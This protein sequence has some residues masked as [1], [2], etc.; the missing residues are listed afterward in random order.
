MVFTSSSQILVTF[1]IVLFTFLHHFFSKTILICFFFSQEIEQTVPTTTTPVAEPPL[2]DPPTLCGRFCRCLFT[3]IFYTQLI[4]ISSLVIFLTFRGL[5]FTKNPNFLPKKWYAP[6]LSS[7]ALSGVLSLAWNC[8]FLCNKAA[9]CNLT[10]F[11]SPML[12]FS[13]GVVILSNGGMEPNASGLVQ[14]VAY[15][16]CFFGVF[17]LFY[18]FLCATPTRRRY[19][20]RVMSI[21]TDEQLPARTRVIAVL[22]VFLS[23]FFAAFLVAGIGGASATGTRLDTLFISLIFIG[24]AWNVQ[25]LKNVQVTAVSKAVYVYFKRLENMNAC[26]ALRVTLRSQLG[27]VCIGSTI[28]PVYVPVRM[29][30]RACSDYEN[31]TKD[32]GCIVND[33]VLYCNRW[34][35][36]HVGAYNKGFVQASRDTWMGFRRTAGLEE[37]IDSDITSSICFE[38]ALLVGAISA[39]TSG[40]WGLKTHKDY[41]LQ[42]TIYP[43]II[44]YFVGRVSSAWLQGC[45]LGYYV[46]YSENP[47]SQNFDDT[48]LQRIKDRRLEAAIARAA[49]ELPA[50]LREE[51]EISY[52]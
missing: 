18:G 34:G 33:M 13:V 19:T 28:L 11:L 17:Q 3:T 43:F 41:F 5:V 45:V 50:R 44:G 46:A 35:F 42:L 8:F 16:L 7:V 6:L 31:R 49:A 4:L 39:L 10:V 32:C 47:R 24:F 30:C 37:L 48:I 14:A 51:E 25:V 52:M 23:V 22:S 2:Q 15:S 40:I 27:S 29:L 9:T 12:V 38:G 1:I 20:F 21:A 26:D 36:V